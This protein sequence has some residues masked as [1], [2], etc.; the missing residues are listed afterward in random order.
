MNRSLRAIL[1]LVLA[2]A[3]LFTALQFADMIS[4]NSDVRSRRAEL[5][6]SRAVWEKIAEEKETLQA[7]LKQVTNDLKEARLSLSESETRKEEL[8]EEIQGLESE[9]K[10]LEEGQHE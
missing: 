8:K 3:F 4:L 7:E 9:I 2:V 1:L 10:A 5:A 6:E